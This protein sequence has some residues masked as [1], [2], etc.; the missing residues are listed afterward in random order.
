M[1]IDESAVDSAAFQ[2]KGLRTTRH[3]PDKDILL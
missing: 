1:Q 3:G 2:K